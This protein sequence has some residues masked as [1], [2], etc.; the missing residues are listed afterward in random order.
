MLSKL[1]FGAGLPT[2]ALFIELALAGL[3]VILAGSRFTKLADSLATQLGLSSG[4]VGLILLATVTSLPE[5]VTGGT[6]TAIGNVDLALGAIFGSCCFNITIIVLL[7]ALLGGG[8]VLRGVSA[9]HTLSSSFGLTL[10]ALALLGMVLVE[11]FT[12]RIAQVCE[13]SWA[14]LIAV[15]Y[16]GGI[17]LI[18]RYER[19][20]ILDG[21]EVLPGNQ[22]AVARSL[23]VQLAVMAGIIVAASWWLA[24]SGDVLSTH[25]IE[26]I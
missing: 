3:A 15:A 1:I 5:L 6:A 9:S 20:S 4:W 14:V 13:V 16:L 7:N 21:R 12:G 19:N 17:R 2:W 11:K 25:R 22:Q 8:S 26:M 23:Y 24:R 10:I 18:F